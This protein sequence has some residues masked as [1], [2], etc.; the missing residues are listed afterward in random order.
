MKNDKYANM[1]SMPELDSTEKRLFP[2]EILSKL[3]KE[4]PIRYDK[5]RNCW[6][7]FTYDD[8]HRVLK[9]SHTFSSVRGASAGQSLLFM[10]PPKHTQMRDLVN[11]AFTPRAIQELAPRIQSIA[12]Q[13]LE[14]VTGE[15]MDLV[16]DYAWRANR[17]SRSF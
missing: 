12:E 14:Q 15:E 5:A 17:R 9:D 2:F 16:R 1:L 4:T 7:V 11:K 10:D 8:V 13:L 6:E 3:R